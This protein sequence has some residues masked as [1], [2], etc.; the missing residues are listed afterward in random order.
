MQKLITSVLLFFTFFANS[1]GQSLALR[2][3]ERIANDFKE[4]LENIEGK[5]Y[6]VVISDFTDGKLAPTELG[7]FLAEEIS[8]HLSSLNKNNFQVLDRSKLEVLLREQGLIRDDLIDPLETVKLGK[9]KGMSHLIYGTII[10][11]REQY[12]VYI[13]LVEIETL[14]SLISVRGYISK[15]PS[16]PDHNG[17]P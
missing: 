11:S 14:A 17:Q 1:N 5:S 4:R 9:L 15:T 12:T 10:D 8:Y 6:N 3:I 13:K 7:R 2:E 16:L